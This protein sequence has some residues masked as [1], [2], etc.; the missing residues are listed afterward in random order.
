MGW[1][2]LI[3]PFKRYI[4]KNVWELESFFFFFCNRIYIKKKIKL[5]TFSFLLRYYCLKFLAK[6]LSII[7][8][9]QIAWDGMEPHGYKNCYNFKKIKVTLNIA[10]VW[11]ITSNIT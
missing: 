3:L 10:Y 5:L 4:Q 1:D 9:I 6:H 8:I 7:I 2:G 11:S